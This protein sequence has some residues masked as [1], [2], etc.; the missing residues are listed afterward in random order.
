M[1]LETCKLCLSQEVELRRSH[2]IPAAAYGVLQES[3]GT[4]PVVIKPAVTIQKNEQA[5]A[6]ILCKACEDRFN[7]HGES[8]LIKYCNRPEGFMF[9]ELIESSP[10]VS[11]SKTRIYSA[12]RIPEIDVSQLVYFVASIM[13]RGSVHTWRSGK[14]RLVTPSLGTKY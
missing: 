6:H 4:P 13:W 11:G 3:T 9:K 1:R 10:L 8:W 7:K 14:E 5:T 12:A 2:F